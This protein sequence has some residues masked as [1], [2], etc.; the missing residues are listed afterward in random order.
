MLTFIVAI[1]ETA[2]DFNKKMYSQ[3]IMK[4]YGSSYLTDSEPLTTQTASHLTSWSAELS[5]TF[6]SL[7]VG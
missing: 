7:V 5:N 1:G 6:V 4:N 2:Y 3:H